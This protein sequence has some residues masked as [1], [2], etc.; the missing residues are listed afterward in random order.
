MMTTVLL[1][2][3]YIR[4]LRALGALHNFKLH[5]ITF[6]KAL[7]T[8]GADSAVMNE[9]VRAVF[10]PDEAE[11][12]GVIKPLYLAFNSRHLRSSSV[13]FALWAHLTQP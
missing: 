8:L 7:V 6:R 5:V 1:G 3:G 2:A 10:P 12:L 9:N 11:S 4:G 13:Q